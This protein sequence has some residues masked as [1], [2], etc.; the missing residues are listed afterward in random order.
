MLQGTYS[1]QGHWATTQSQ[2]KDSYYQT[3]WMTMELWLEKQNLL[4][5][6]HHARKKDRM[7]EL[8]DGT[9]LPLKKR[10][11]LSNLYRRL[12]HVQKRSGKN[13]EQETRRTSYQN[14]YTRENLSS[15][16]RIHRGIPP[17]HTPHQ[18][19]YFKNHPPSPPRI[20]ERLVSRT[21]TSSSGKHKIVSCTKETVMSK[22]YFFRIIGNLKEEW[23]KQAP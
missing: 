11:D 3:T 6:C 15:S 14:A 1:R 5:A 12:V 4:W 23:P 22:F 21:R 20:Q 9:F 13:M 2:T 7:K 17:T 16:S 19:S 18:V 10:S 8:E